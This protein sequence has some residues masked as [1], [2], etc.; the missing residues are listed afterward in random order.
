MSCCLMSISGAG[1][2]ETLPP[3]GS[4]EH[5]PWPAGPGVRGDQGAQGASGGLR[6]PSVVSGH[7]SCIIQPDIGKYVWQ[8][9]RG[10]EGIHCTIVHGTRTESCTIVSETGLVTVTM[11]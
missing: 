2:L 1:P 7:H 6:G 11:P 5:R 4:P 3:P 9:V 8:L 10:R